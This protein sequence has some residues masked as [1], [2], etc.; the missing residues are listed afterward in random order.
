VVGNTETQYRV[1]DTGIG[2]DSRRW[3]GGNV[4]CRPSRNLRHRN[5][6]SAQ[7][8]RGKRGVFEDRPKKKGGFSTE[9][10][11]GMRNGKWMRAGIPTDPVKR[12]AERDSDMF[13]GECGRKERRAVEGEGGRHSDES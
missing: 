10:E 1:R 2:E 9:K 7:G 4:Q 13:T 12:L 5:E 8:N 11:A 3:E 6:Y